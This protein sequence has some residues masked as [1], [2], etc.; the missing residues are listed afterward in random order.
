MKKLSGG[1][2]LPGKFPVPLGSF[3]AVVPGGDK[4]DSYRGY[5]TFFQIFQIF[6]VFRNYME[7]IQAAGFQA[8][9]KGVHVLVKGWSVDGK[10]QVKNGGISG[11]SEPL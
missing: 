11:G 4:T 8:A 5:A 1:L 6:L 3:Q 9:G 10:L 7:K 2:K